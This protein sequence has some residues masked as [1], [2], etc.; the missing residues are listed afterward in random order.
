MTAVTYTCDPWGNITGSSIGIMAT[1]NPWHYAG[2][3]TDA[4]TGYLKARS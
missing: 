2:S 4:A 3:N 1:T